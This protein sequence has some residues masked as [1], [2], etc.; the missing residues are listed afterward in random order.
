M[1]TLFTERVIDI[2]RSV[3]PGKVLTYG[4][5][6]ALAGN[7]RA[8]RQVSRILHSSSGAYDLPWHRVVNS[9]GGISLRPG[10]GGEIQRALLEE[11][12]VLFDEQGLIDLSEYLAAS[13]TPG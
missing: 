2:I 9:K 3:P 8:S 5:V 12:G 6:A 1:P 10:G 4:T 7:P 11:E 13:Y